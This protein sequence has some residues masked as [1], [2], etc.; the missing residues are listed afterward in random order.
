MKI[1][2][3]VM[4]QGGSRG[5]VE[6]VI[7]AWTKSIISSRYELRIFHFL[8]GTSDYLDGYSKQWTMAL[9]ET[10]EICL[11]LKYCVERYAWFVENYGAPDI[12]IATWIPLM[13]SVCS[14]VRDMLDLNYTI[15]SWLHSGIHVYKQM[16]WGGL[17]HLKYADYHFCIS[18]KTQNDIV[19]IYNDAKTFVIGNPVKPVEIQDY[20]PDNRTLCFVGR[21]DK[22]KRLDVI[23]K[24]LAI[25]NDKTWRLLIAGDGRQYEEMKKLSYDLMLSDRVEF[26]GWK[27]DPWTAVSTASIL[28]IA[29]DYEGF[30][31]TALEASSIGMTVIST[32]VSGCI[33]YI[34]PGLNGYFYDNNSPQNLANIL[35]YISEGKLPV[36]DRKACCESVSSYLWDNYFKHVESCLNYCTENK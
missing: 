8:P 10:G 17:E 3:I 33:D 30:S 19:G 25:T 5:G 26:L 21:I 15:I 36:C 4:P 6:Y 20:S 22:E 27:S 28:L 2:D 35:N 7:N 34:S 23:L 12:C 24:A 13:T 31:I 1:I 29:S 16:G 11:D 32:P 9:P 18:E 14:A